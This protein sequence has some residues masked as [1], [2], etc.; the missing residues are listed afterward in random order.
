MH[1]AGWVN[2]RNETMDL[3]LNT[4]AAHFSIGSLHTPI[5]IKGP[6]KSLSIRPEVGGL[7]ARGGIAGALGVLMPPLA[8]L[9]TIEFGRTKA[10]SAQRG[11]PR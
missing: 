2:L 11:F 10:A 8:I 6:L 9:G 4:T 1:G 7:M 5:H 3:E